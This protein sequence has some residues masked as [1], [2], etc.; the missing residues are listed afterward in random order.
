MNRT[1]ISAS[2]FKL[3]LISRGAAC[4]RDSCSVSSKSNIL[5]DFRN[6]RKCFALSKVPEPPYRSSQFSQFFGV[7][8]CLFS[9]NRGDKL[10]ISLLETSSSRCQTSESN[11]C[12]ETIKASEFQLFQSGHF[13]NFQVFSLE[14]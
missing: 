1:L 5:S 3:N 9:S 11:D 2:S 13:I 14:K 12:I 10:I 8:I 4:R 7:L 6:R